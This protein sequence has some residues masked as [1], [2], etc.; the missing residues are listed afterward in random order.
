MCNRSRDA[1]KVP[2]K[3]YFGVRPNKRKDLIICTNAA[4]MQQTRLQCGSISN[5][6]RERETCFTSTK[7]RQQETAASHVSMRRGR[8]VVAVTVMIEIAKWPQT[9]S[10]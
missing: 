1:P 5:C 3:N 9:I 10:K 6:Q 8:V 4:L 2:P 7:H